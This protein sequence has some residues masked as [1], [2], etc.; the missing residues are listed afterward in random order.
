MP[1]ASK[2]DLPCL[3][4][5]D[6]CWYCKEYCCCCSYILLNYC[7][8]GTKFCSEKCQALFELNPIEIP[9]DIF[10]PA[11][12][13]NI[14]QSNK[15]YSTLKCLPLLAFMQKV[16]STELHKNTV[17]KIYLC[18]SD[19][20]FE[21]LPPGV[22]FAICQIKTALTQAVIDCVLSEDYVPLEP[23]WYS[24]YCEQLIEK[25]RALLSS[26]IKLLVTQANL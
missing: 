22:S 19:E 5:E 10:G 14:F 8:I 21:V 17:L 16:L 1:I 25:Y 13:A 26:E 9:A 20:S 11:E 4:S 24:N 23:V 12:L 15:M 3:T 18:K 2:L 7:K 6:T